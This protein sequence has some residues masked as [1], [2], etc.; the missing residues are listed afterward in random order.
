MSRIDAALER[1]K[2]AAFD[3]SM[4]EL[5]ERAG[6]PASTARGI[7]KKPPM[8]IQN[9]RALEREAD[10]HLAAKEDPAPAGN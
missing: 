9:L 3:L 4:N 1:I 2:L 6:V 7:V 5:A 10:K 8:S